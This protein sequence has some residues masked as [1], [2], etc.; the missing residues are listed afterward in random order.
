MSFVD[1][2]DLPRWADTPLVDPL[3]KQSN[4]VEPPSAKKDIGFF[5]KE[6]PPRNWLNWLLRQSYL[7]HAFTF[8]QTVSAVDDFLPNSFRTS[9]VVNQPGGLD[10]TIDAVEVWLNGEAFEQA[11]SGTIALGDNQ[12]NY[13]FLKEDKTYDFSVAAGT[14]FRRDR[15]PV[16]T[17]VTA[18]G[19]ITEMKVHGRLI[20][21]H[22]H[23]VTVGKDDADFEDL[24]EAIDFA[25][26][27]A[28]QDNMPRVEV[29]IQGEIVVP[30]PVTVPLAVGIRGAGPTPTIQW[31]FTDDPL[32]HFDGALASFS[33][34]TNVTFEYT[35][36]AVTGASHSAAKLTAANDLRFDRCVFL[37]ANR[38]VW[39]DGTSSRCRISGC[40]FQASVQNVTAHV[41]AQNDS[42]EWHVDGCFFRGPAGSGTT[43]AVRFAD[44]SQS[45]VEGC[46]FEGYN[47]HVDIDLD[48]ARCI[49]LGNTHDFPRR[50]AVW[51]DGPDCK[52][53]GNT[54]NNPGLDA[55]VDDAA[56][57]VESNA[58]R[59]VVAGNTVLSWD[60]GWAIRLNA[61]HA[62]AHDNQCHNP[63][64]TSA[65]PAISGGICAPT[66]YIA[67]RDNDIDL[68]VG[69]STGAGKNKAYG[70]LTREYV[71]PTVT[72]PNAAGEF[73]QC[74][75]NTVRNCGAI[76][77]EGAI[78][79]VVGE[80]SQLAGNT[81]ENCAGQNFRVSGEGAA[82][83]GNVMTRY[84]NSVLAA[85]FNPVSAM[86]SF[87]DDGDDS[88]LV[89]NIATSPGGVDAGPGVFEPGCRGVFTRNNQFKC[90]TNFA[91]APLP[92]LLTEQNVGKIRQSGTAAGGAT[93]DLAPVIQ[94]LPASTSI[95]VRANVVADDQATNDA[96]VYDLYC[97]ITTD[98]AG[99]IVANTFALLHTVDGVGG[100]DPTVGFV[101]DGSN[102]LVIR[103]TSPG[104]KTF[105]YRATVWLVDEPDNEYTA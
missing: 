15:L 34:I 13:V 44:S 35:G 50:E 60:G 32:L 23:I 75:G 49:V 79:I 30:A 31:A 77:G 28:T 24:Q 12:T 80:E 104:G 96:S 86:W 62:V 27:A 87:S 54:V 43:R 36:S 71:D 17:V 38:G 65:A 83:R 64:G 52:I 18:G 99:L 66:N 82:V 37:N 5:Y 57:Q 4:V 72:I 63:D 2:P 10:I 53:G 33:K 69:A 88:T 3:S 70:I 105:D 74:T 78:G 56:I 100:G 89:D 25:N 22:R 67:V 102:R 58:E 26:G 29:V 8:E 92:T 94:T 97:R 21:S 19:V 6:K 20:S 16:A 11:A 51:C 103:C 93:V 73:T 91:A 14:A 55:G 59:T 101:G 95:G 84:T 45:Q 48:S 1:K 40:H 81:F 46:Y 42:N 9:P 39:S 68:L 98:A 61:E 41:D 85:P 7:S 90:G 47:R 76:G